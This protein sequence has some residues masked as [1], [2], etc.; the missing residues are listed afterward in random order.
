MANSIPI[1]IADFETSLASAISAGA[2]S[3]TLAS[4]TDDDGNALAAGKYC[5]TVN[6]GSSNK[7]YL[8]GQ[9]NGTAVTSVVSVDRRG[10]ETSGAAN[11][12]RAGSPVIISDFAT[13]QRVADILR[14][15]E[16]LDGDNP[17]TYD[18]EPTL[19]NRAE[20]ATVGY[21]LDQVSGGTVNF[22]NQIISSSDATAGET[23]AAG[24]WVFFNTAD[25]EW[26]EVDA[27]TAAEVDGAYIGVALGSGTDGVSITGGIQISGVYTTTGLTPGSVYYLSNTPGAIGTSAGT[28]ERAVGV[29]L[30]STKLLMNLQ[31]KRLPTATEKYALAGGGDFG[32]PSSSNKYLT[33]DWASGTGSSE[34]VTF[35]SSGTWTKDSN[36]KRIR[37]QAWGAGGSGGRSAVAGNEAGGGGGGGYNEAWFE[38][39]ELGSTETVT[40]GAGGASKTINS[41]GSAGGNT[42]FGSL[43][44]AYGGGGGGYNT[45]GGAGGGGGGPM[46]AGGTV[47]GTTEGAAGSPGSPLSGTGGSTSGSAGGDAL[48]GAGGGGADSSGG[49]C[50]AGGAA[51]LG[52]AG[53]GAANNAGSS[54][55]GTSIF[56][57]AGGAGDNASSGNATDGTQP[58]GGGGGKYTTGTGNS[59]AG[60]DG[61][62]IV[63]EYYI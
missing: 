12:A 30:S 9:L 46:G 28:T 49:A 54:A 61:Q 57:G 33:Q 51:Y 59:G 8:I 4:A 29:A 55:G 36:L 14:G 22:D 50:G 13:I 39:S 37:V 7:Q 5:F 45:G 48:Y 21:V 52:G 24:D 60:G 2:T 31:E 17:I 47:T 18:A 32:T 34:V 10:N 27:D 16:E 56:G 23:I 43:L 44:T 53:G 11:A 62:I 63:T 35:T 58:G 1:V 25:Q 40:I 3:L 15:Q 6:N 19:S 20:V 42:T 41:S 26:Y 38:A